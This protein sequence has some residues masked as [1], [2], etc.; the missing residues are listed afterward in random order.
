MPGDEGRGASVRDST[1]FLLHQKKSVLGSF[2]V[3]REYSS[4]PRENT[5]KSPG[6]YSKQECV[7]S[8]PQ[9]EMNVSHDKT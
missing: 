8:D 9:L 2:V 4:F 5:L 7:H 6:N 1:S 3:G